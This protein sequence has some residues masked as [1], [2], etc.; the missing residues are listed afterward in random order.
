MIPDSLLSKGEDASFLSHDGPRTSA[1]LYLPSKGL[2]YSVRDPLC[3]TFTAAR[4]DRNAPDFAWFSM[5]LIQY[6]TLRGF[7]VLVPNVRG[8]TGYGLSYTKHVDC[9]WGGQDRLD[10]AHAMKMFCQ[11]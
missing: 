10:H 8:S 6:L 7:A 1:R 3:T 5:P 2:G 4:R 11:R 9:D